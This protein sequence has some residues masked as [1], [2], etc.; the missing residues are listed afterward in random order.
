MTWVVDTSVLIDIL[1]DDPRFGRS[2]A[3]ALEAHAGDGVVLCPVSYAELAPAFAGDTALQE[4]FLDAIGVSYRQEWLW[5]DTTRAHHAWN[6]LV[7]RRRAGLAPKRPLADILIG[8]FA[9]RYEG[10]ITRNSKDFAA[11]FPDLRLSQASS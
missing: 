7:R 6:R 5:A 9:T 11:F 1:E 2:S 8:A 10:L 3:V 4:R